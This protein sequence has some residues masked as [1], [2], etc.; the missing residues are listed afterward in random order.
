VKCPTCGAES[1][2][3]GVARNY[4]EHQITYLRVCD[5]G[6]RFDTVEV[7]PTQLADAREMTCALRNIDRRVARFKR[8]V[9]IAL[10]TRPPKEVAADYG[11]T[12]ARVRQIRASFPNRSSQERWARITS[13]LERVEP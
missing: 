4:K 2:V 8:D 11:I 3:I 10:D 7:H 13:N 5:I 12:D 9:A 1:D 6:H